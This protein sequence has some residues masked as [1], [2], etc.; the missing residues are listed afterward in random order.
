MKTIINQENG[1]Y[2]YKLYQGSLINVLGVWYS[3]PSENLGDFLMRIAAD[4]QS[5]VNIYNNN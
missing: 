3:M 1:I 4:V 5:V 2:E